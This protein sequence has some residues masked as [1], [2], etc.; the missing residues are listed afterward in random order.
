[1]GDL[2]LAV[3]HR[4]PQG[5]V[6]VIDGDTGA[7]LGQ[8]DFADKSLTI[9]PTVPVHLIKPVMTLLFTYIEEVQRG[10]QAL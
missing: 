10:G 8:Y 6:S 2:Q 9:V 5:T 4:G 3:S 1:M 7:T